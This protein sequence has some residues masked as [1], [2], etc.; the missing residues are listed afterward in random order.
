MGNALRCDGR[1][2]RGSGQRFEGLGRLDLPSGESYIGEFRRGVRHGLGVLLFANGATYEGRFEAD[3]LG[4]VGARRPCSWRGERGERLT[5]CAARRTRRRLHLSRA[6]AGDAAGAQARLAR[7]LRRRLP[8]PP[9]RRG[10]A[11]VRERT[12]GDG[13]LRRAAEG[14]GEELRTTCTRV[15]WR[16][17]RQRERRSAALRGAAE[18]RLCVGRSRVRGAAQALHR[19]RLR[20]RGQRGTDQPAVRVARVDARA[21]GQGSCIDLIPPPRGAG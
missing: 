17:V 13:R 21:R 4:P 18:R 9:L 15:R 14:G 5:P 3:V 10:R 11:D 20:R 7:H 16:R 19:G 2:R 12:G 6:G 8:Q 1:W